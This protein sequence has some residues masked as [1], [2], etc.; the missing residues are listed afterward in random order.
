MDV[1][2][3]ASEPESPGPTEGMFDVN[4]D[5]ELGSQTSAGFLLP[6]LAHLESSTSW[7]PG[8]SCL[9][10][11]QTELVLPVLP[12]SR[13]NGHNDIDTNLG[14]KYC[15]C[16]N[17]I[18]QDVVCKNCNPHEVLSP[19][20]VNDHLRTE[21]SDSNETTAATAQTLVDIRFQLARGEYEGHVATA[22]RVQSLIDHPALNSSVIDSGTAW[23]LTGEYIL[24]HR[25]ITSLNNVPIIIDGMVCS[26]CS[27]AFESLRSAQRHWKGLCPNSTENAPEPG[28]WKMAVQRVT[29]APDRFIGGTASVICV[30][31]ETAP[32][33]CSLILAASSLAPRP[34]DGS[35]VQD[36]YE[37]AFLS[38][39]RRQLTRAIRGEDFN[40][41]GEAC[42]EDDGGW[43]SKIVKTAVLKQFEFDEVVMTDLG[44]SLADASSLSAQCLLRRPHRDATD[45]K[46][47]NVSVKVYFTRALAGLNSV[48]DRLFIKTYF[49]VNLDTNL[50]T[51]ND[52]HRYSS[53]MSMLLCCHA[54]TAKPRSVD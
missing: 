30:I 33:S 10:A 52:W 47:L 44:M 15:L 27:R 42:A 43:A 31:F 38:Q 23:S 13:T 19:S 36:D 34:R 20:S 5:L 12:G 2:K 14:D 37:V 51:D 11:V 49:G 41:G 45:S 53:L 26:G 29:P 40:E 1:T 18:V 3:R 21:H 17:D 25:A 46:M 24:A 7:I 39:L 35:A 48:V 8:G 16:F 6:S 4:C 22:S 32:E 28:L 50:T 9:R 54:R